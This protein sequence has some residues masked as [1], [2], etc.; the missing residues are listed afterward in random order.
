MFKFIAIISWISIVSQLNNG[1]VFASRAEELSNLR[2]APFRV[3]AFEV[4]YKY[5]LIFCHYTLSLTNFYNNLH[6]VSTLYVCRERF[7]KWQRQLLSRI[8]CL[9]Y[10]LSGPAFQ[11][12]VL[13]KQKN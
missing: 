4:Q 6:T 5:S 10:K 7:K 3:Y 12:K 2:G 11:S 9:F 8:H 13:F 1:R